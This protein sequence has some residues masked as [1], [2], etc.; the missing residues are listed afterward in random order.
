[1]HD[2]HELGA[3][4]AHDTFLTVPDR[5]NF[6]KNLESKQHETVFFVVLRGFIL[7]FSNSFNA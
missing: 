4:P 5:G 2:G 6:G 7:Y 3:R 1:M